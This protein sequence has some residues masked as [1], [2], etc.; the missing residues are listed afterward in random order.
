MDLCPDEATVLVDGREETVDADE[1][2]VGSVIIIKA[3]ERVPINSVVISGT[4][5]V[6]TSALTGESIPIS[7][8]VGTALD[9]GFLVINGVLTAKTT[10][11]VEESSASRVLELVEN[12]NERK[13]KT[14]NFITKFSHVYTPVV[15]LLAIFLATVPPLCK[16]TSWSEGIYRA[17]IF[18]VV[19][20]PC[21]LVISVPMAFFGG[22]GAAASSGI[23]YKGGNTFSS[24]A[25]AEIFAFD[26]TGTLTGGDFA[27]SGAYPTGVSEEELLYLSASAESGS[28]H[29]IAKCLK[30]ASEKITAPTDVRES[31]GLG[32]VAAVDGNEI[33]V[34][35]IALLEAEQVSFDT[36]SVNN[37]PLGAVHVA[38]NKEYIGYI[39][40][41]DEIKVEA[42]Q[43]IAELRELGVKK[44]V[45][46]SGDRYRNVEYVANQ[47]GITEFSSE[48]L[49]EDKYNKLDEMIK[50]SSG[51]AYVG[52]G[53]NDA[54]SIALADVGIAMGKMGQDSAIEASDV[55]IM[56][57]NLDRL[58]TAVR[59]A[60]R[61]VRIA[62]ENIVFALGVK[63]I[64]LILGALG[65]ANMWLAVFA[66]VGV[67][68]L[69]ILNSIRTMNKSK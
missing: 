30:A 49:P 22:I 41:S 21:A 11:R 33:A 66:D 69:A 42:K 24:L 52:D 67:S 12:A 26:K 51:V 62:K 36:E 29:P 64:I 48:L 5:D 60:R 58:P 28:N 25:R 32:V 47:V 23:L 17:L 2:E 54:P 43:T 55:V 39:T 20:C 35:N 38:K 7:A 4:A 19:S 37:A 16:L 31:A 14:E 44:T 3:G 6:D 9:S 15:V 68:A 61:T 50:T 45:L 13:S 53:I 46:L 59:I 63:G 56:S 65:F 1:V 34:G 57:D 18:L 10:C 8:A 40:V 27:V